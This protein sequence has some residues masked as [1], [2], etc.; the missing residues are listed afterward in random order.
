PNISKNEFFKFNSKGDF[1]IQR[2]SL[3]RMGASEVGS[4]FVGQE[5]ALK[6]MTGKVLKA[7]GRE[8]P[9]EDNLSMRKGK[10]L[11]TLGFDEF[12]RIYFDNIQVL[13]KNK[14][15]NGIDK[16]NYFKKFNGDDTLVGATIDGWFV[17]TQGEAELLEINIVT[18]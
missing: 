6:L 10:M 4:I 18:I 11:E 17:N 15:A 2:E 12:I 3:K 13:H 1:S 16:Y 8:I 5:S 14:Y 9:F 7:L